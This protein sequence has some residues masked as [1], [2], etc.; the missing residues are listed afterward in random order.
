MSRYVDRASRSDKVQ[1]KPGMDSMTT[2]FGLSARRGF[3]EFLLYVISGRNLALW[4]F[5]IFDV[6]V[7]APSPDG[8]LRHLRS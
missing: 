6:V 8:H 1:I 3:F 7:A 2:Q 5:V 4:F